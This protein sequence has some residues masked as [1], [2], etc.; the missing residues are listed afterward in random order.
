MSKVITRVFIRWKL[1]DQG[2]REKN[3]K[4]ETKVGDERR[5]YTTDGIFEDGGRSHECNGPLEVRESKERG[6]SLEPPEGS[7]TCLPMP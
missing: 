7:Q 2:Q 4:M 5:F 3:G 6:S 1:E